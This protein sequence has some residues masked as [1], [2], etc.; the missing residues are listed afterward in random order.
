MSYSEQTRMDMQWRPTYMEL[1]NKTVGVD[2]SARSVRANPFARPDEDA[3]SDHVQE[4]LRHAGI[5]C[6]TAV[7]LGLGA[8][9][10][11]PGTGTMDALSWFLKPIGIA[12]QLVKFLLGWRDRL[13]ALERRKLL[14]QMVVTLVADH[15][16]PCRTGP[17]EWQDMAR[18][19]LLILPD[20]QKDLESAFPGCNFRYKFYA[21]GRKI[22]YVQLRAG[23]GLSVTDRHVLQMLKHLDRD[24]VSLTLFHCEGWFAFPR[25]VASSSKV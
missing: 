19:L 15:I 24:A 5:A 21:R 25:V 23:N 17:N 14:P 8:A 16:E 3:I 4:F 22:P 6:Q 13:A 20:L 11:G 10:G 1:P 12:I 2:A 9:A 7:P 18:L